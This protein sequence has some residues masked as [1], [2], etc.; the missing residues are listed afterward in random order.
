M[1]HSVTEQRHEHYRKVQAERY[2]QAKQ[3]DPQGVARFEKKA[4]KERK[5]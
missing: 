2:A 1:A 3:S 4:K 5:G